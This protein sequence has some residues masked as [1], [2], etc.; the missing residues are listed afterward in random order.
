MV[1]TASFWWSVTLESNSN[2][3]TTPIACYVAYFSRS[4]WMEMFSLKLTDRPE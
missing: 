2:Q 3:E 4:T 1:S